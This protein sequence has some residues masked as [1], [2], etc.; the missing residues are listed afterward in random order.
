MK[1]INN[2]K[3]KKIVGLVLILIL[4]FNLGLGIFLFSA[5]QVNAT[6]DTTAAVVSQ[7]LFQKILD[8][9]S[10]AVKNAGLLALNNTAIRIGSDAGRNTAKMIVSGGH[11]GTPMI[12]TKSLADYAKMAGEDA[13]GEFVGQLNEDWGDTL[14]IDLC[15]PSGISLSLKRSISIRLLNSYETEVQDRK[16]KCDWQDVRKNWDEFVATATN[17]EYL[18]QLKNEFK[19]K[20]TDMG[21]TLAMMSE[22]EAGAGEA[23][24]AQEINL[25]DNRGFKDM[26]DKITGKIV[27]PAIDVQKKYEQMLDIDKQIREQL[28]ESA[29]E[30]NNPLIVLSA[31]FFAS[32]VG[33]LQDKVVDVLTGKSDVRDIS[34]R[35]SGMSSFNRA[36]RADEVFS[37]LLTAEIKTNNRELSIV[38]EFAACPTDSRYAQLNNCV[39]DQ[40]LVQAINS[41]MTIREALDRGYLHGNWYVATPGEE[42]SADDY[43][44]R[45]SLTNIKK[46]RKARIFPLGLEIAARLIYT[47]QTEK[48]N[49]TLKEIVDSYRNADYN[50]EDPSSDVKDSD[51]WHLVDPEWVL[52]EPKAKCGAT[53]YGSL[54]QLGSSARQEACVSWEH[55]IDEDI[56]GTCMDWGYCTKEKLVRQFAGQ[57]CSSQY[58]SC[59]S[60][61]RESDNKQFSYIKSSLDFSICDANN[62][63][64]YWYSNNQDVTGSWTSDLDSRIYL[65]HNAKEC[66]SGEAGCSLFLELFDNNM[67]S[68]GKA[69][70]EEVINSLLTE[71]SI[72]D[73]RV[74]KRYLK[75]AP[76]YYNCY[77][78]NPS[79]S[80]DECDNYALSCSDDEVGC[81]KYQPVDGGPWIPAVVSKNDT[82]PSEC[83]GYASYLQRPLWW[84]NVTDTYGAYRTGGFT[85]FIA[86]SAEVC[87]AS[88]V[89]CEAY[90]SLSSENSITE[91]FSH[92]Q[93]CQLPENSSCKNYYTIEGDDET[94]YQFKSY[95]FLA[96]TSGPCSEVNPASISSELLM[97]ASCA[98]TTIAEC[99]R[100]FCNNDGADCNTDD[101]CSGGTC[102]MDNLQC[103]QLYT[104]DGSDSVFVE[105]DKLTVCAE[106]CTLYR[107]NRADVTTSDSNVYDEFDCPAEH[108]FAGECLYPM[109]PANSTVCSSDAVGC[110]EYA[111]GE[112]GNIRRLFE[113]N[114]E[115]GVEEG[116][117][118]VVI[119]G[120]IG[121]EPEI[122]A[123]S[124]Y[125]GENSL[126][127]NYSSTLTA[128]VERDISEYVNSDKAYMLSFLAKA[129]SSGGDLYVSFNP[130]DTDRE[131]KFV[132]KLSLNTDWNYYTVGPVSINWPDDG[133][134]FTL[135]ND[136]SGANSTFYVDS[137][138]LEEV[139]NN[140]FLI[141]NS[142]F[143]PQTC[144]TNPPLSY[145]I[146]SESMLGC[147]QYRDREGASHYLK[148]FTR[149]C[150][151]ERIGCRSL[152]DVWN[153][154]S[155][156]NGQY[157]LNVCQGGSNDR[158]NCNDSCPAGEFCQSDGTCSGSDFNTCDCPG[159]TCVDDFD[160]DDVLVPADNQINLVID[161]A[162]S[163]T[164]DSKGCAELGKPNF[165][166]DGSVENY[167][168]VYL[169]NDP[170]KYIS[171]ETSNVEGPIL[172]RDEEYRCEKFT[173]SLGETNYFVDPAGLTCDYR[174]EIDIGAASKITGWFKTGVVDSLGYPM[175]C[176]CESDEASVCYGD[177][178]TYTEPPNFAVDASGEVI[179]EYNGRGALC[180]DSEDMCTEFIDPSS[181]GFTSVYYV[182]DKTLLENDCDGMVS[183]KK[184]CLLYKD[185]SQTDEFNNVDL[186]WDSQATYNKGFLQDLVLVSPESD[187]NTDPLT[188]TNDSNIILQKKNV[189]HDCAEWLECN[190]WEFQWDSATSTYNKICTSFGRCNKTDPAGT[191]C[192]SD[193][194]VS[195][196]L[197]GQDCGDPSSGSIVANDELCGGDSVE[198]GLVC[199]DLTPDDTSTDFECVP[200][201]LTAEAYQARDIKFND[202][203]A[204]YSGYSEFGQYPID[205]LREVLYSDGLFYLDSIFSEAGLGL[206]VDQQKQYCEADDDCP[207]GMSCNGPSNK[208][209]FDQAVAG[210]GVSALGTCLTD[211]DCS[212]E[213][214]GQIC[215]K[216]NVGDSFGRCVIPKNCRGFPESDS[217]FDRNSVYNNVN[218]CSDE[219]EDF[220]ESGNSLSS[221][222][223]GC[224][225]HYTKTRYGGE[226][227]Y[228]D[229][230]TGSPK[231]VCTSGD[232][233]KVTEKASCEGKSD[234]CDSGALDPDG[235]CVDSD[236][237]P[238]CTYKDREETFYG[239]E[240]VC[241]EPDPSKTNLATGTFSCLTWYPSDKLASAIDIYNMNPEAGY[242]PHREWYG[243]TK[244]KYV[245]G[246]GTGTSLNIGGTFSGYSV[247]VMDSDIFTNELFARD[248][249]ESGDT[250]NFD[251][252]DHCAN[253]QLQGEWTIK[254][255]YKPK[256]HRNSIEGII[257]KGSVEHDD[258]SSSAF[259]N[260]TLNKANNWYFARDNNGG[261]GHADYSGDINIPGN[262]DWIIKNDSFS[263][264]NLANDDRTAIVVRAHFD[265]NDYLASLRWTLEHDQ[266]GDG[267]D[268]GICG[269]AKMSNLTIVFGDG[270][271][272]MLDV[273]D[274]NGLAVAYTNKTWDKGSQYEPLGGEKECLDFGAAGLIDEPSSWVA[275]GDPLVC[276]ENQAGNIYKYS[277]GGGDKI[278]LLFKRVFATHIFDVDPSS[279]NFLEYRE[280]ESGEW[281]TYDDTG[282]GPASRVEVRP[283][284]SGGQVNEPGKFAIND[285]TAG[286][287]KLYNGFAT[288]K[289]YAW[290]D[291][292]HMPVRQVAVDWGDGFYGGSVGDGMMAKN[293]KA[294]CEKVCTALDASGRIDSATSTS[295]EIDEECGVGKSCFPE[296]FGN[297]PEAC[298]EG[299]WEFQ[300]SYMCYPGMKDSNGDELYFDDCNAT[301]GVSGACCVFKPRLLVKDN[302]GWTAEGTHE[303]DITSAVDSDGYIEY[304]NVDDVVIIPYRR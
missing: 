143:T 108:F 98:G 73:Y 114:F 35:D 115:F 38:A 64:C 61:V 41:N 250:P 131:N 68:I 175:P 9:I 276:A 166:S 294:S 163:C 120:G 112:A 136:S 263:T 282:D 154:D 104:Q 111:G 5:R 234:C 59:R 169:V 196:S 211:S 1:L 190:T 138:K 116:W 257:F 88:E 18:A 4:V 86:S 255:K 260:A 30:S 222:G 209:Y 135:V 125:F 20:N 215:R 65:N 40:G 277:S 24:D 139:D 170:D 230:G 270:A 110:R 155:V 183:Q 152:V 248:N 103:Q 10:K 126:R 278:D 39:I 102:I 75:K 258:G 101:E 78:G 253:S 70:T 261:N 29:R 178:E 50:P 289:F 160:A 94:G 121:S 96:N 72:E 113:D 167:T 123:E 198:T 217:P 181:G 158:G 93:Y 228:Y 81:E 164:E 195:P 237:L 151:E 85:N 174:Q 46:L 192:A 2:A 287:L 26:T 19:F 32:M 297:T 118:N 239:W 290:A 161:E 97:G 56:D 53:T 162:K 87:D 137:V 37:E 145:G 191:G 232:A 238:I 22:I 186:L 16:A 236:N 63:G 21:L 280:T 221:V 48:K 281:V 43:S 269:W 264:I 11:G 203:G 25:A 148:S 67:N 301:Y 256:L 27:K 177:T 299:W 171:T 292:N 295:C 153:S 286:N 304:G 273:T 45:Y 298:M 285:K 251:R 15:D 168:S 235:T 249:N 44:Q 140:L 300:H 246:P 133:K 105:L 207:V 129:E 42:D 57:E 266:A 204:E 172:C 233:Q 296:T 283:S 284:I 83:V 254:D 227:L 293:R 259:L 127:V 62:Y 201:T 244:S 23:R 12:L 84:D 212:P 69:K 182:K 91:Y 206:R 150:D 274:E 275:E 159:G 90:S 107:K 55:C 303:S 268:S 49:I 223:N 117:S 262:D 265:E 187:L 58:A 193:G 149:L 267:S 205:T 34:N 225:C 66:Q 185:T 60:Y 33:E 218:K 71:D 8:V 291:E 132:Q 122:S 80:S 89:G 202:F 243:V 240:G 210:V 13:M 197:I 199:M 7:T 14:G 208:C 288:M 134:K 146:A 106:D 226:N 156:L 130:D 6:P 272:Y 247:V 224:N 142:W 47:G 52:T 184:G 165:N 179:D 241:L 219:S 124:V 147:R 200:E 220:D 229:V 214:T 279:D 95:S 51:F 252:I 157:N 216:L 144:E 141:Q 242:M 79:T 28:L 213:I 176:M 173:N 36:K 100:G 245:V 128:S 231:G 54:P 82:C 180:P 74:V 3:R 92:G 77:D 109:S 194:W 302:W 271:K 189:T 99:Y 119:G 76:D 188:T 17:K 31:S